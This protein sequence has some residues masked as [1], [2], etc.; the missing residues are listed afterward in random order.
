MIHDRFHLIKMLHV[1]MDKACK[2]EAKKHPD[3]LRYGRFALLKHPENRT[4]KQD[5]VFETSMVANTEVGKAWLLREAFKA[6]F[7]CSPYKDALKYFKLW[8]NRVMAS[9]IKEMMTI[10]KRFERHFEG[11]LHALNLKQSNARAENLNGGIQKVRSIG[12]GC[13][14]FKNFRVATLFFFGNIDLY[15]QYS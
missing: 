6:I 3:I 4:E 13:R 11:V 1:G 14:S 8:L 2:R 7:G 12:R 9:K 5:Q 15:P 10:V